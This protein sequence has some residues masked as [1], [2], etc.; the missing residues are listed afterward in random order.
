MNIFIGKEGL[1]TSCQDPFPEVISCHKCGH[2]AK[3]MFVV[4]ETLKDKGH[5]ISD[6]YTDKRW[7]HDL[8]SAAV[9]FCT[10]CLS[11]TALVNQE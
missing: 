6:L 7:F 3:I 11:P 1:D 5:F 9:Y 4:S 2:P 8:C 10:N